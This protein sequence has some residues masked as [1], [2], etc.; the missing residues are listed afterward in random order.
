[1]IDYTDVD[2]KLEEYSEAFDFYMECGEMPPSM[3]HRPISSRGNAI[4]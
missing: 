2:A 1:M 4:I 3:P